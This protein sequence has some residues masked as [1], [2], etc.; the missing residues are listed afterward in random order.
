MRKRTY[1]CTKE[2]CKGAKL[3]VT[4]EITLNDFTTI[5]EAEAELKETLAEEWSCSLD[6]IKLKLL[7]KSGKKRTTAEIL[8]DWANG[9]F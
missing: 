4:L 8:E 5:R 1:Q 6:E 3:S 7:S 2:I 9:I